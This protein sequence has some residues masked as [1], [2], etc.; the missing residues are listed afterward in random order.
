[1]EEIN[2]RKLFTEV[3]YNYI[4]S[5]HIQKIIEINMTGSSDVFDYIKALE[6][7]DDLIEYLKNAANN[8]TNSNIKHFDHALALLGLNNVK[9]CLLG[10]ELSKMLNP[11]QKTLPLFKDAVDNTKHAII[12]EESAKKVGSVYAE[13]AYTCGF[14]FDIFHKRFLNLDLK[15]LENPDLK[16]PDNV[17][18]EVFKNGILTGITAEAFAKNF[19]VTYKKYIFA[20]GLLHNIGKLVLF[21]YSPKLYD[22]ILST[23]KTNNVYFHQAESE[24]ID[25]CHTSLGSLYLRQLKHL[26]FLEKFIDFHHG[27]SILKHSDIALYEMSSILYISSLIVKYNKSGKSI[28]EFPIEEVEEELI[29]FNYTKEQLFEFIAKA[30]TF[31][32]S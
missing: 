1:M 29:F 9:N 2:I 31:K 7:N 15:N 4:P 12:A 8:L 21:A 11:K 13:V 17:I 32:L 28:D 3:I 23:T 18:N 30:K 22:S 16:T 24:N 25:L 5:P 20:A 26:K 10:L 14:I 6:D 19:K 27:V